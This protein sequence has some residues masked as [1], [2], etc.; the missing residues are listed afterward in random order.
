M[1]IL[2]ENIITQLRDIQE[3]KNWIGS[4]FDKKLDPINENTAFIRP[5]NHLHS[6][7]ELISHLTV[8]RNETILKII[9]GKGSITD[10]CEENWLTN[11]QLKEIGW[12]KIKME[13]DSSL[14]E[15]I[16]LLKS[17]DDSFLKEKYYDTDFKDFFEFQFV[18]FGMLHHDIYH[19]GQLGIIVKLIKQKF[20]QQL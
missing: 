14:S 5:A 12:K 13:Y 17:K 20:T 7:A 10:E 16:E 8:W 4:N 19:L 3:G 11:D 9:T 18:I 6:V 2:I 15:I 1:R